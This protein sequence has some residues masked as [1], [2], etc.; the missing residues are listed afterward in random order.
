MDGRVGAA[1]TLLTNCEH[2]EDFELKLK[3]KRSR[4]RRWIAELF[5]S[6]IVGQE[7]SVMH[8]MKLALQMWAS[9]LGPWTSHK[10]WSALHQLL[11]AYSAKYASAFYGQE[12]HLWA[13]R[14]QCVLWLDLS[15]HVHMIVPRP[16][17][18]ALD[19]NPVIADDW[20]VGETEHAPPAATSSL[21]FAWKCSVGW[22]A[23]VPKG[24]ETYQQDPA[25]CLEGLVSST[26][27]ANAAASYY[28][29]TSIYIYTV[30]I[31]PSL[32]LFSSI[33]LPTHLFIYLSI[34]FYFIPHLILSYPFID[35]SIDLYFFFI[36]V[37]SLVILFS[38]L[39]DLILS[40]SYL[41]ILLIM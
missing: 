7:P 36:I 28:I 27:A 23:Q 26:N 12:S 21:P 4:Q 22:P 5:E 25:T 8:S 32:S 11:Q 29:Y 9:W 13:F 15:K 41:S 33:Y 38:F 19:S 20:K 3:L 1:D 34:W 10:L 16:F 31:Y 6:S 17:R 14:C 39:S 18:E 2:A 24:K 37:P 30:Y 40:L 35:P